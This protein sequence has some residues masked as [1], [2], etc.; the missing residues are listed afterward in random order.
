[1][2]SEIRISASKKSWRAT[3]KEFEE[4]A[5]CEISTSMFISARNL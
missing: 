4:K 1:M 3:R 2:K 5:E